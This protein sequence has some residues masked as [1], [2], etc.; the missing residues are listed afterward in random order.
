[1]SGSLCGGLRL[2]LRRSLRPLGPSER[3]RQTSGVT[4][5]HRQVGL[6]PERSGKRGRVRSILMF[7]ELLV[8]RQPIF[9]RREQLYGYDLMLR[10]PG[11]FGA[12]GEPLPE[13]LVAD[14]FLGIGI[15]QVAGGKR[16]F[17][18]VDRDMI[19]GGAARLLPA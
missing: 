12:P 5:N 2:M 3:R 13:Q 19:M 15:D 7:L 14:T 9:D 10:R 18:T 17:V 6:R 11:G 8:A 4:A 1:M 16:A